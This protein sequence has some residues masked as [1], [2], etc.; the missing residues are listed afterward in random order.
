MTHVKT[1]MQNC[2]GPA[3]VNFYRSGCLH[4]GGGAK[5]KHS[6]RLF[7]HSQFNLSLL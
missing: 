3:E 5:V 1:E 7:L 4:L 2:V 6:E